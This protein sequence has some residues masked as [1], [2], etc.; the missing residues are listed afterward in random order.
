V[1]KATIDLVMVEWEDSAQPIARWV[2]LRDHDDWSAVACLSVGWLI[3]KDERFTHSRR[4]W[5]R[6][7]TFKRAAK[8]VFPRER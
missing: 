2:Y 4:T 1:S 5:G 6:S 7:I 3:Q 8:S